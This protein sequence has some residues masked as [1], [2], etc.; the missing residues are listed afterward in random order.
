[1]VYNRNM[2]KN[3]KKNGNPGIKIPHTHLTKKHLSFRK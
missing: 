3:A 1:M 2:Q